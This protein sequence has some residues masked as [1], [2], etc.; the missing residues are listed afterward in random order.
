MSFE[1]S[2]C[3]GILPIQGCENKLMGQDSWEKACDGFFVYPFDIIV[4][5]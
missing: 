5:Q 2:M 3:Y 4:K 1:F